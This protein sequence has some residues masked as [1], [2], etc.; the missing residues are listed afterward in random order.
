MAQNISKRLALVT[1]LFLLGA[2]VLWLGKNKKPDAIENTPIHTAPSTPFA[3]FEDVEAIADFKLNTEPSEI[4]KGIAR[5]ESLL[6]SLPASLRDIPPP[7]LLDVDKD[8]GLIINVKIKD[9]FDHYLAAIGEESIETVLERIELNLDLQLDEPALST[10]L[11]ILK[12]YI[13]YRDSIDQILQASGAL[14]AGNFDAKNIASLKQQ[15][16]FS[17]SKFFNEDVVKAFFDKEDQ[18]DDYMLAKSTIANDKSLDE[19]E[20][21]AALKAIQTNTPSWLVELEAK[22]NSIHSY[23]E[24]EQML[25]ESGAAEWEIRDFRRRELGDQAAENLENLDQQRRDWDIRLATYRDEVKEAMANYDDVNS[26][27][28]LA[29]RDQIRAQH[30]KDNEFRRVTSLDQI[31][32]E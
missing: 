32:S 31:G 14:N 12:G 30:F 8:G 16:R 11:D 3:S 25:R 26:E 6:S 20:K 13:N 22:A 4:E 2:V 5:Q 19:D 17:R 29:K 18:Y 27:D 28:A 21:L 23:Q 15:V 1:A 10:A 7:D 24:R 9:M